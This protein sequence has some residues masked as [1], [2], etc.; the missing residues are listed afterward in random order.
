MGPGINLGLLFPERNRMNTTSTAGKSRRGFASMDPEK[1][2]EIARKGGA[3][4]PADKRSFS[5]DRTLA[6]TA[7]AEGGRQSHRSNVRPAPARA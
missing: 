7:G 2:R 3:A 5:Q 6:A 4:V 1:Q